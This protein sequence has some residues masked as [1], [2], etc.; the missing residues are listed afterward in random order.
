MYIYNNIFFSFALDNRDTYKDIGGDKIAYGGAN[1]DLKG[2]RLYNLV[3]IDGLHTVLTAIIDYRG[4]RVVAQSIIP[5]ILTNDKVSQVVYGSIDNGKNVN[6]EQTFHELMVKAGKL[7]HIGES[8]VKKNEEGGEVTLAV[9]VDSKGI[10]G[11]D[12]RKCIHQTIFHTIICDKYRYPRSHSSYAPRPQLLISFRRYV[13]VT[14][15]AHCRLR[16]VCQTQDS[17]R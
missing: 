11:T 7:L 14:S 12:G 9:A 13:P 8:T 16:R 6:T 5:G 17:R 2:V 1:N 10:I 4:H 15:R 3:D